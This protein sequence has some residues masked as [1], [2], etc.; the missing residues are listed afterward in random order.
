MR[1]P[2]AWPGRFFLKR[3]RTQPVFPCSR[4]TLPQ[5]ART[6]DLM[7]GFFGTAFRVLAL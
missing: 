3:A 4:V 7:K 2:I 1:C 5:M 6:L